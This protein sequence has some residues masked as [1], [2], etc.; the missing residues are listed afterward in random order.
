MAICIQIFFKLGTN[1]PFFSSYTLEK[2]FGQKKKH[3][4]LIY[5]QKNQKYLP[6]KGFSTFVFGTPEVFLQT[7]HL[8]FLQH[9]GTK[10]NVNSQTC[11]CIVYLVF[12]L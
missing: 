2:F 4:H 9:G 10:F 5:Y 1:I 7:I 11:S 8:C 3:R 6:Q 12:N